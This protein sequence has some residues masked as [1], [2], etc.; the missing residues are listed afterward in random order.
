MAI[1]KILLHGGKGEFRQQKIEKYTHNY[2]EIK[3]RD[4]PVS[5]VGHEKR[6][7]V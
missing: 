3:I 2:V 4:T 1:L 7:E 5:G 6:K